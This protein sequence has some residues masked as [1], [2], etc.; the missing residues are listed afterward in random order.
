MAKLH[1]YL[2]NPSLPL[3][4]PQSR[5]R[6]LAFDHDLFSFTD[7]SINSWPLVLITNPK[8]ARFILPSRE[9]LKRISFSSHIRLLAFSPDVITSVRVWVD[10]EEMDTPTPVEGGP[11]YVSPWKPE[12]Y[13]K[14]LH[15]IRVSVKVH[16]WWVCMHYLNDVC[17][18]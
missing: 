10:D 13:S 16:T 3:S 2:M 4:L 11:L 12:L 1:A 7:T 17:C 8:D 6:L 5:Y 15:T 9:P 14:G 18:H